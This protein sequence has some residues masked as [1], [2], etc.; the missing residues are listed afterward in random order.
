MSPQLP[1][2]SNGQH[3]FNLLVLTDCSSGSNSGLGLTF[4]VLVLFIVSFMDDF[5]YVRD[6]EVCMWSKI[7]YVPGCI[8][9]GS[10]NFGLGILLDD[11]VGLAGANG[12]R[13]PRRMS[14]SVGMYVDGV[15]SNR[16]YPYVMTHPP[17]VGHSS[18]TFRLDHCAAS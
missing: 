6:V 12:P 17:P 16:K 2:K 4:Q 10:R 14:E 13:F 3:L 1:W 18:R 7:C 9:Y 8:C 5:T 15:T 11:Y